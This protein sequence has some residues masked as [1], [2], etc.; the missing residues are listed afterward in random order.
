[1]AATAATAKFRVAYLSPANS[2]D[3]RPPSHRGSVFDWTTLSTITL[4]GHGW[5]MSATVSPATARSAAASVFQC[6]RRRWPMRGVPGA[7][8]T[9]EAVSA[10]NEYGNRSAEDLGDAR[11]NDVTINQRCGPRAP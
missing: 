8:V 7:R 9:S 4:I 5:R 6:G 2:A 1:M 3:T 11:P 10:K